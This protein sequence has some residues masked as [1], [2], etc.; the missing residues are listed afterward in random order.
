M[1]V[2]RSSLCWLASTSPS[3]QAFGLYLLNVGRLFLPQL[4]EVF[5]PGVWSQGWKIKLCV[6]VS[7]YFVD[8]CKICW[9][10]ENSS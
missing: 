7:V 5:G 9:L 8:C 6:S 4:E 2:R 3:K 10:G 1:K